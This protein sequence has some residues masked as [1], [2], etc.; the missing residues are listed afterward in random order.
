LD[1]VDEEVAPGETDQHRSACM[2]LSH[3]AH[4]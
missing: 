4:R 2:V 3:L 1:Q